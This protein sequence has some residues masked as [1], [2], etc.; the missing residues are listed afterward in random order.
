MSG[1]NDTMNDSEVIPEGNVG[2]LIQCDPTAIPL[3]LS[4]L[5]GSIQG[6]FQGLV[7][8]E[9]QITWHQKGC[10]SWQARSLVILKSRT[11][12]AGTLALRSRV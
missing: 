9:K 11:P 7:Q 8:L 4:R 2:Y 6:E 1:S 5:R 3:N 12:E 10:D